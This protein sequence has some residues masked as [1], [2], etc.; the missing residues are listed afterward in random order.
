LKRLSTG[1][2]AAI[3]A[4]GFGLTS[5]SAAQTTVANG[6]IGTLA[7]PKTV[8]QAMMM[9]PADF[10]TAPSGE[11]PILFNDHHVYTKPDRLKQ[12]RVL[13]ALVRGNE[14]LVPLRSMFEQMGAT[15]SYDPASKTADV[16]KPGSDVKVTVGKPEVVING[17]SR[18]L[19]VPPEIYKGVIVVPV[20]VISEGMG[21]YVQW[22][23]EKKVV[24]V[25]YVAAPVPTPP[26][27]P[28]PT[29]P[30]TPKPTPKPTPPPP[31]PPPPTP[32]PSPTPKPV[33]YEHFIVGDYVFHPKVYNEFSNGIVGNNNSY[34]ARGAIE[35]PAFGLPWMVEGDYRSYSYQ[36]NGSFPARTS[37]AA[38][39]GDPGD[40]TVIGGSGQVYVPGFTATDTDIDGRLGFKVVDPRI[41]IGVGYLSRSENYGYPRQNGFGFGIE[42]L[43]DLN[44]PFSIYGSAWYY[45]SVSANFSSASANGQFSYRDLK[46]QVGATYTLGAFSGIGIFIDGGYMGDSLR[47]KSLAPSDSTHNGP[48]LGLGLKF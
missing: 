18:P 29:A 38:H 7:T 2:L 36:H 16:S 11:V 31:P 12:N 40:V 28:A 39:P 43:P 8:A 26:P 22:V 42:K 34:A 15:V 1:V 32:S 23:P 9:P 45:P 21:A 44:Q 5:V 20:R 30:P 37:A 17:E 4:V 35:F 41:Y 27:T 3:V 14:I 25:R 19:D 46:Y 33:N 24:V 48:Y 10:G 6:N 13:A 47:S